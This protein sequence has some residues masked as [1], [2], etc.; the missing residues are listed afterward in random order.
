MA[1]VS[2]PEKSVEN[3]QPL[4]CKRQPR[5]AESREILT[6]NFARNGLALKPDCCLGRFGKPLIHFFLV[7]EPFLTIARSCMSLKCA[8]TLGKLGGW[9]GRSM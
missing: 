2:R 6:A 5:P 9:R 4:N 7:G 3:S 1:A 8:A